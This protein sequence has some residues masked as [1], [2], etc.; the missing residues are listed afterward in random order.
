MNWL[1]YSVCIFMERLYHYVNEVARI[2][3]KSFNELLPLLEERNFQKREYLVR[4]EFRNRYAYFILEGFTR[5]F[6]L[7][8]DTEIA[9]YLGLDL[10]TL[11]RIR[12]KEKQNQGN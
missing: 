2:S 8:G 12:A 6:W 1:S 9:S 11:S 4:E 5:S 10:S 3:E 7:E